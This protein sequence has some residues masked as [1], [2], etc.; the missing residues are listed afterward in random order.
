M[1]ARGQQQKRCTWMA[2]WL[3]LLSVSFTSGCTGGGDTVISGL[4]NSDNHIGTDAIWESLA[5][6]LADFEGTPSVSNE[7]LKSVFDV[8]RRHALE[9]ELEAAL[10]LLKLAEEQREPEG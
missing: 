7:D 1:Q 5:D 8:I 4:G 2:A 9:G 10:V 6:E 3:A